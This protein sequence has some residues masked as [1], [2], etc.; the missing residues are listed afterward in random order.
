MKLLKLFF[1]TL[2]ILG[3]VKTSNAEGVS[4]KRVE[5]CSTEK[6]YFLRPLKHE[7][8][9]P[10]DK[11]MLGA[12]TSSAYAVSQEP[13][14]P[15]VGLIAVRRMDLGLKD[16]TNGPNSIFEIAITSRLPGGT[17]VSF[18]TEDYDQN[19]ADGGVRK[20]AVVGGTGKY[21][22]AN[23]YTIL[24]PYGNEQETTQYKV[25]YKLNVLCEDR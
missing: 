22:G 20:R 19:V 4:T 23:G 15:R 1:F 14:G 17:V 9:G 11:T 3:L 6:V 10:T 12:I 2:V 13:N 5:F 24:E 18:E 25:T 16:V 21:Q 7:A 8:T